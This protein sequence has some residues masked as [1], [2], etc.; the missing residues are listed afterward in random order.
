MLYMYVIQQEVENFL[1]YRFTLHTWV[2]H[3]YY[4]TSHIYMCLRTVHVAHDVY[5][6]EHN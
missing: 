4:M 2:L 1:K 5:S 3:T 6:F